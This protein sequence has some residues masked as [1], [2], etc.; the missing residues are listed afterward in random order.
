MSQCMKRFNL[1]ESLLI[2]NPDSERFEVRPRRWF[3][4]VLG[5]V[6]LVPATMNIVVVSFLDYE[7]TF[8]GWFY[9]ILFVVAGVAVAAMT[10]SPSNRHVFIDFKKGVVTIGPPLGIGRTQT[11]DLSP[12]S[13]VSDQYTRYLPGNELTV[14]QAWIE[15]EGNRVRL[16]QTTGD[17]YAE[18]ASHLAQALQTAKNDPRGA[19]S[20]LAEFFSRTTS[21][22]KKTWLYIAAIVGLGMVYIWWYFFR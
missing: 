10:F 19:L 4:L 15:V 22:M 5:L 13:F 17:E 1:M 18:I 3:F 7:L 9:S 20:E 16:V 6:C 11:F 12:V 8:Y 21:P 14:D 2:S